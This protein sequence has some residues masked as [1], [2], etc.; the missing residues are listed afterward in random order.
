VIPAQHPAVLRA[1]VAT[2]AAVSLTQ[3]SHV[4]V[5]ARGRSMKE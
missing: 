1:C 2:V 3:V 4:A 5:E